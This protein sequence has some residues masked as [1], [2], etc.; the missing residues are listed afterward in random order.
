M[1]RNAYARAADN[2][3]VVR[4]YSSHLDES[5]NAPAS[6]QFA[7]E[8]VQCGKKR[9]VPDS[10][11]EVALSLPHKRIASTSKTVLPT[12]GFL[13]PTSHSNQAGVGMLPQAQVRQ[14]V[15]ELPH[16]EIV[17]QPP[18]KP[19]TTFEW[20]SLAQRER[21]E[22]ERHTREVQQAAAA[23]ADNRERR[24]LGQRRRRE[25]E[26]REREAV[27][28]G[29]LILPHSHKEHGFLGRP[30]MDIDWHHAP[31]PHC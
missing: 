28:D 3:S 30:S 19:V 9:A 26:R 17:S 16:R 12:R 18:R 7:C 25:R 14:S 31:D 8:E 4:T 23:A 1:N 27:Q 22:R 5:K 13:S 10:A 15:E 6:Q 11:D 20:R 21:Q 2:S 24:S 29:Q